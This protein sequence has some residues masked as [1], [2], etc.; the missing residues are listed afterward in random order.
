MEEQWPK[1]WFKKKKETGKKIW[2]DD[3]KKTNAND[4]KYMKR[5]ATLFIKKEKKN[6]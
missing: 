4:F 6:I 1:C 5:Y 2:T 3:H